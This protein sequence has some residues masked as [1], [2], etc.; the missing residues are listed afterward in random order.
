MTVDSRMYNRIQ[1]FKDNV[2]SKLLER[3]EN[4]AKDTHDELDLD[5]LEYTTALAPPKG[6]CSKEIIVTLTID[7]IN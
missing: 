3:A 5:T 6:C 7:T 4:A 2:H 1:H